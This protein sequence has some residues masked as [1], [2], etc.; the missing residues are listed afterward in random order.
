MWDNEYLLVG[1]D[2]KTIKIINLNNGEIIE[3]IRGHN[4]K[5]I[6]LKIINHPIYGKC[7][8]SQGTYFEPIKLWIIRK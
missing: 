2:D 4:D 7:L 5:V 3:E 6:S 8:L 1:C